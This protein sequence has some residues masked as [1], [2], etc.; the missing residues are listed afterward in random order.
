MALQFLYYSG[1][2]PLQYDDTSTYPDMALMEASRAPQHYIENEPTQLYHVVRLSGLTSKFTSVVVAA[3]S[4][5]IARS[6]ATSAATVGSNAQGTANDA[7]SDASAALSYA[8]YV[9]S[10]LTSHMA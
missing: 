2:G 8:T 9:N 6:M 3:G 5:S 10:K 7:H 4:D 1:F